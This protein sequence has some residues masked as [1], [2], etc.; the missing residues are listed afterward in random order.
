M[1][2]IY[3]PRSLASCHWMASA[4]EGVSFGC[5]HPQRVIPAVDWIEMKGLV[6]GCLEVEMEPFGAQISWDQLP[7]QGS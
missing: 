5:C 6:V 3:F 4:L 1:L 2:D 7:S